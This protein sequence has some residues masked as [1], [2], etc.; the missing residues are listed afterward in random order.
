MGH[1][2]IN[3]TINYLRGL[4]NIDLNESDMPE[5]LFKFENEKYHLSACINFCSTSIKSQDLKIL[6]AFK[7]FYIN[8][9]ITD[10][11]PDTY[12]I[13]AKATRALVEKGM[14]SAEG[15]K[16]ISDVCQIATI[17][18]FIEK[19]PNSWNCGRLGIRITSCDNKAIYLSSSS[20]PNVICYP[21]YNECYYKWGDA[22]KKHIRYFQY[23]YNPLLNHYKLDL[24]V[25]EKI[26][27]SEESIIEYLEEEGY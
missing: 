18:F 27:E 2:T 5:L 11:N 14:I 17:S 9:F 6:N 1:S 8:P 25:V 20:T 4:K 24:P 10:G 16:N 23:T 3:V 12:G 19:A 26:S 21:P 13:K 15:V 22:F 7:Y